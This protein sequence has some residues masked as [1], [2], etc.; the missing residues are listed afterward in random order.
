MADKL[1][2]KQVKFCDEYVVSLDAVKSYIFAYN[3]KASTANVNAYKLLGNTRVADYVQMKLR[4]A[5]IKAEWT[6]ADILRD[7]KAIAEDE[8]S[9]KFEKLKALELGG[10]HLGMFTERIE[11]HN[12]NENIEYTTEDRQKRIA[13]L[14]DKLGYSK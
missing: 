6:M 12:I 13:E 9:K 10:K 4:K 14:Q 8:T 3:C 1:S 2:A 5:S 11:S 7:I